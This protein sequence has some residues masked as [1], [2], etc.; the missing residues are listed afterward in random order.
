M[1]NIFSLKKIVLLLVFLLVISQAAY[2]QRGLGPAMGGDPA[3]V[4]INI[5]G[6]NEG[7][8]ISKEI[9]ERYKPGLSGEGSLRKE[10][11]EWVKEDR[12]VLREKLGEAAKDGSLEPKQARKLLERLREGVSEGKVDGAEFNKIRSRIEKAVVS[13][14]LEAEDA[15]KAL[16]MVKN[17]DEEKEETTDDESEDDETEDEEKL[18][19]LD[20]AEVSGQ[21]E[22]KGLERAVANSEAKELRK[23]ARENVRDERKAER[24]KVKEEYQKIKEAHKEVNERLKE[25]RAELQACKTGEQTDQCK[26][27]RQKLVDNSKEFL[28]S[29]NEKIRALIAQ[30]KERIQ[31]SELSEERKA[32]LLEKLDARVTKLDD[33]AQ[34]VQSSEATKETV[35]EAARLL[36][37][38]WLEAKRDIRVS[39]NRVAANKLRDVIEKT[40]QVKTNLERMIAKLKEKGKNTEGLETALK[41]FEERMAKA[42]TTHEEANTLLEENKDESSVDKGAQLVKEAHEELKQAY[43]D[44]KTLVKNIKETGDANE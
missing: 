16:E 11:K 3:K 32:A 22:K 39:V 20:K 25:A 27:L 37:Q 19:G 15:N 9:Q 30:A 12:Q 44:L 43:E 6:N 8:P 5:A 23:E 4:K 24:E 29:T 31:N 38:S 1:K 34:K 26:D 14:K 33:L 40:Q 7:G 2:A 17:I 18:T 35:R 42:R 10:A 21:G 28:T 36:R 41:N 13:G